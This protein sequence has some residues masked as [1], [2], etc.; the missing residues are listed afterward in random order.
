MSR[1]VN[2]TPG[3]DNNIV[4]VLK[5]SDG[6]NTYKLATQDITLSSNA[7]DGQVLGIQN[8]R[9][10]FQEI[11]KRINIENEGTT[12][13]IG[14]ISFGIARN[15]SNAL[16][17]GFFNEFYPATSGKYLISAV[18]DVG[19]VW[20]SSSSEDD[21]TWLYQYRGDDYS[22]SN[23]QINLVFSEFSEF[24]QFNLPYYRIQKETDNGMSYFPNCPKENIGA[25]I[26]IV[27]GDFTAYNRITKDFVLTPSLL[28]DKSLVKY[29]VCSHPVFET[30]VSLAVEGEYVMFIYI[31]ELDNYL[32]MTKDAGSAITNTISHTVSLQ[33]TLGDLF[34]DIYLPFNGVSSLYT[35][36]D[37]TNAIDNSEVTY[38]SLDASHFL[39]L[40][41]AEADTSVS[42]GAL[43]TNSNSI[44]VSFN[45]ASNDSGDRDY[46]INVY[47]AFVSSPVAG[48]GSSDTLTTGTTVTTYS[49]D[50]TTD[51]NPKQT[52]DLPW[53]INELLNLE[54]YLE[55]R[56]LSAGNYIQ[57][58]IGG[59]DL[60]GI[61]INK[62]SRKPSTGNL[63]RNSMGL[64]NYGRNSGTT[65]KLR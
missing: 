1:V 3:N 14:T 54:Y 35:F 53:N 27:Y 50:L 39:A 32:R 44:L 56:E 16:T 29:I 13:E 62:V 10:S 55:N 21:I 6:T 58:Y 5:I 49:Y 23:S 45:I 34:G 43:N 24:E 25:S 38:V 19:I 18:A 65:I 30:S 12:G 33:S 40:R 36:G 51:V 4:W 46:K 9:L 28:I 61:F 63:V 52:S 41:V 7:W 20:D 15:T 17:D 59:I 2:M 11:G 8:N 26:P 47:N 37:V 31:N 60:S 48:D 42:L 57:V 64:R 22:Y